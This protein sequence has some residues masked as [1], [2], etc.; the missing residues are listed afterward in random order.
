MTS[1]SLNC[2]VLLALLLLGSPLSPVAAAEPPKAAATAEP[3]KADPA[4]PAEPQKPNGA[5]PAWTVTCASPGRAIP[6]NCAMEQRLFAKESGNLMS[7]VVVSVPG[8]TRQPVLWLQLPTGL[9]L[10]EAI[11][12]T[13]DGEAPR[14]L[15]VQS[16]DERSCT[17]GLPIP[18]DLLAIMKKGRMMT[19]K[20]TSA[21][22]EAL[23]FPHTL[24]D[25]ATRYEAVQ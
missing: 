6:A 25:F 10:Q 5:A 7:V 8:T 20:A 23:V 4:K 17:I 12:L 19:V 15:A 24:A 18:P 21:K 22:R 3:A 1:P 14:P 2:P 13:I 9:A 11:A 16:C